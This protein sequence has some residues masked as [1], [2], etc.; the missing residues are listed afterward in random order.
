MI[1]IDIAWQGVKKLIER[2]DLSRSPGPD[3]IC[4]NLLKLIPRNT[5]NFLQVICEISLRTS[6]IPKDLNAASI[7]PQYKKGPRSIASNKRSVSLKS[8]P[9]KL[10]E[11]IIKSALYSHILGFYRN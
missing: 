2:L 10:L 9:C 3:D 7:I 4:P 8:A 5:E 6:E 11:H 1:D